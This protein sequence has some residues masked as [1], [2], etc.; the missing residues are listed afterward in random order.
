MGL[1][2]FEEASSLIMVSELKSEDRNT[3]NFSSTTLSSLGVTSEGIV[4][5]SDCIDKRADT[6]STH[7]SETTNQQSHSS[8]INPANSSTASLPP[9]SNGFKE[10][11]PDGS[12]SEMASSICMRL[13]VKDVKTIVDYRVK[14]LRC[15]QQEISDV[16][17]KARG[18]SSFSAAH[19]SK[20]DL[21]VIKKERAILM[22]EL[23]EDW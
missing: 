22:V 12:N 3:A 19:V 10:P 2:L 18:D 13:V 17:T 20:Q 11:F 4:S 9:P 6:I 21:A 8:S 1:D 5:S 14:Q 16:S 23:M 7:Y 15:I